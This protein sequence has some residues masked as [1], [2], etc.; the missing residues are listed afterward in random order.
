VIT[1]HGINC[2]SDCLSQRRLTLTFVAFF[3]LFGY[4]DDQL[5]FI[6]A[7]SGTDAMRDMERT[8]LRAFG[9]SRE[10]QAF[11]VGPS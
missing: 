8:A 10:L 6:K 2:N 5:A 3:L 11:P 1:A 4:S 9:K 7:A